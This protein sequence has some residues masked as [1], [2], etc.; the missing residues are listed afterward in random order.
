MLPSPPPHIGLR[1]LVGVAAE[2][3]PAEVS[4]LSVLDTLAHHKQAE[5]TRGVS[6]HPTYS[7]MDFFPAEK[8][9]LLGLTTRLR[10]RRD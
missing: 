8:M 5:N 3:A 1:T 7:K 9:Y 2:L 4:L 10:R 6:Y